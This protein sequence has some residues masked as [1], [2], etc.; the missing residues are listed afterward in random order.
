LGACHK[1]KIN[2][3]F[4]FFTPD[5]VASLKIM[6]GSKKFKNLAHVEEAEGLE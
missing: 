2:D 5:E 4:D 6:T 3:S 1:A